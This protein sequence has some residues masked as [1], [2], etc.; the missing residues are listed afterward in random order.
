MTRVGLVLVVLIAMV[1]IHAQQLDVSPHTEHFVQVNG[2]KIQYLDWV[3]RETDW[4][5]SPATVRPPTCSTN[6]R[7]SSMRHFEWLR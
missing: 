4:S 2:I 1:N 5:F 6:S 7:P 3:A